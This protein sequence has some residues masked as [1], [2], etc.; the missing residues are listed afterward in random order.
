MARLPHSLATQEEKENY[1]P[2]DVSSADSTNAALRT[3]QRSL[4]KEGSSCGTQKG[5]GLR[6]PAKEA[7]LLRDT[8]VIFED[9]KQSADYHGV[10]CHYYFVCWMDTLL[11]EPSI[12]KLPNFLIVMDN[13]KYRTYYQK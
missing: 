3:V 1:L 4:K 7:E 8:V 6:P 9:G 2:V 10:C 13:A 12:R 5:K 11:Q